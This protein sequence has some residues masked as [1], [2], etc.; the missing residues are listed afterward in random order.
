MGHVMPI[1]GTFETVRDVQQSLNVQS[2]SIVKDEQIYGSK[3]QNHQNS[4]TFDC[5]T[6]DTISG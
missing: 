5:C 6:R 3:T 2:S 4:P 1:I